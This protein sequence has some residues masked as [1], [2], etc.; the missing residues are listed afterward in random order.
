M[1]FPDWTH[2]N[3]LVYAA[4]D[5]NLLLSL[6]DQ[7]WILK[8]DYQNGSGSSDVLWTLGYRG[9]FEPST[10]PRLGLVFRPA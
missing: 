5:G 4:D 3:A 7:S 8:I 10:G 2:A 6:R 9:D 1:S